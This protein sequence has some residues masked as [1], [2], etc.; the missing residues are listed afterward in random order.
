[1]KITIVVDGKTL[2]DEEVFDGYIFCSHIEAT[3][4]EKEQ[5]LTLIDA[6]VLMA[7]NIADKICE[8][9]QESFDATMDRIAKEQ[10]R[11]VIH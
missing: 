3:E 11:S 6:P 1:M 9:V 5:S 2:V 10:A 4:L 7:A 8:K